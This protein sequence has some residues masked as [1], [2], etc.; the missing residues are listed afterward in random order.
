MNSVQFQ[1][2][3]SWRTGFNWSFRSFALFVGFL[4]LLN[5]SM[6]SSQPGVWAAPACS[7]TSHCLPRLVSKGAPA[8]WALGGCQVC[9]AGGAGGSVLSAGALVRCCEAGRRCP[10]A[11]PFGRRA[12]QRCA[13]LQFLSLHSVR[14]NRKQSV[15]WP[16]LS[17]RFF[18]VSVSAAGDAGKPESYA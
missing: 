7:K 14:L 16:C 12:A 8:P 6:D 4:H 9:A 15:L 13:N 2:V 18:M 10:Q 3:R 11:C 1:V 5:V 17:C